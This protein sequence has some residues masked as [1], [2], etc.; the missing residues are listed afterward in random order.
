[1]IA[2]VVEIT[3]LSSSSA[4]IPHPSSSIRLRQCQHLEDVGTTPPLFSCL[5]ISLGE[6]CAH[7]RQLAKSKISHLHRLLL[8]LLC[9]GLCT[10]T[11]TQSRRVWAGSSRLLKGCIWWVAP[12]SNAG[13]L[14]TT[15]RVDRKVFGCALSREPQTWLK[16]Q[17]TTIALPFW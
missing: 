7:D 3:T 17:S 12:S 4:P 8:A 16:A 14:A 15:T 9:S 10:C 2:A 13:P 5:R 11:C 6:T 1:M